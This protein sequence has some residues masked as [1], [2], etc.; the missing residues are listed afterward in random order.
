ML[1]ASASATNC[2]DKTPR[3]RRIRKAVARALPVTTYATPLTFDDGPAKQVE[4]DRELIVACDV[5]RGVDSPPVLAAFEV[6]C[7]EETLVHRNSQ[8]QRRN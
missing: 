5:A 3:R 4:R 1:G 6:L 8:I 7:H 2:I